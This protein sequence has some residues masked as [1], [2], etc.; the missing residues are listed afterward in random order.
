[1]SLLPETRKHNW[2]HEVRTAVAVAVVVALEEKTLPRCK[3]H[4]FGKI[5]FDY[6]FQE[7]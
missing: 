5:H 4:C 1:M 6:I 3:T 7:I 2:D